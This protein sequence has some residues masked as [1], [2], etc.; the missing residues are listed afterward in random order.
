MI[1]LNSNWHQLSLKAVRQ[2]ILGFWF[3]MDAYS[4]PSATWLYW[5]RIR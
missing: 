4:S 1:S 3:V 2:G 5:K